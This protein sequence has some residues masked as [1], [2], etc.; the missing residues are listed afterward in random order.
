M[1]RR[2][3][4]APPFLLFAFV[5]DI[6]LAVSADLW[7]IVSES[8]RSTFPVGVVKRLAAYTSLRFRPLDPPG[9]DHSLTLHVD[10]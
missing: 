9:I 5:P 8:D 4:R 2:N 1:L 7:E 10:L 6:E 3:R